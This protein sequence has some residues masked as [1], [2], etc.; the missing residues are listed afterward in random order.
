MTTLGTTPARAP[1]RGRPGYDRQ[2]VLAVAVEAFNEQGYD[3]TSV[4][5]LAERLGLTKSAMYHHFSSKEQLLEMALGQALDGLEGV[6]A[7]PDASVGS[8]ADR[9]EF[10]LR[11]AVHVLLDQLPNVTLLL[12]L[13]GNSDVERAA[14]ERRR[15]FDHQ[16]TALVREAQDSGSVRPDVDSGIVSRLLFGMLN[17]TIEWYRPG[18]AVDR[19]AL[20]HDILTIAFDGIRAR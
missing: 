10:V 7:E 18:K 19:D 8:A 13:R 3:A 16:M 6:L 14:L 15:A 2:E 5:D 1:R 9:L 20:T 17:S 4:S 11:A 12:R